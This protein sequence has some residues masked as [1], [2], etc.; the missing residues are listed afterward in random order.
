MK[1]AKSILLLTLSSAIL[2]ACSGLKSDPNIGLSPSTH[3]LEDLNVRDFTTA[4]LQAEVKVFLPIS[5]EE[6]M[7]LVADFE[8]YSK[9]VSP[10][11]EKVEID[12]SGTSDGSF[13]IGTKVSYKEGESDIIEHYD[14]DL[15]LIARPLWEIND[16]E[17]H[18]GVVLASR[19]E[20]GTI[21]HMR[22]YFEPKGFK[23]WFMSQMMPRF[24]KKSA[25]NLAKQYN[26]EVL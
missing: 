16:F 14:E 2:T 17:D 19:H 26:G 6:A 3:N 4:P 24:M 22:R 8:N 15:A 18:R 21:L 1:T 25:E 13:G 12:N 7:A 20:N 5:Q 10:P 11:P 23:G 9:W